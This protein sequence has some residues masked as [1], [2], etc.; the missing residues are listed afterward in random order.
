MKVGKNFLKKTDP[1]VIISEVAI[2]SSKWEK[3][4]LNLNKNRLKQLLL[5]TNRKNLCQLQKQNPLQ[6]NK[7]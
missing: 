2:G 5:L 6:K 1:V 3:T 4:P 7:I